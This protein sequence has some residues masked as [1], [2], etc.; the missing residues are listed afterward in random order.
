MVKTQLPTKSDYDLAVDELRKLN[1]DIF[2]DDLKR[3]LGN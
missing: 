1:E 2:Y 3:R